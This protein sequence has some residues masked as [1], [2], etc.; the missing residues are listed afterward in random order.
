MEEEDEEGEKEREGTEERRGRPFI[1]SLPHAKWY[2]KH[3]TH[4]S[5]FNPC[6]KQKQKTFEV[7]IVILTL[8]RNCCTDSFT[9]AK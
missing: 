5:S 8:E 1:V 3:F 9:G 7:C 6:K 4:T 2:S